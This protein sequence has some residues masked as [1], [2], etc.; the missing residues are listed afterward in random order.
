V[1][2]LSTELARILSTPDM[3]D[4]LEKLGIEAV[5]STPEQAAR[6]LD[7]EIAK[8]ARVINTAGIKAEP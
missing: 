2:R 4:R 6:F 5:G 8:W 1:T 3:R 7:D